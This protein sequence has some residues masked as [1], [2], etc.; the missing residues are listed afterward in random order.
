MPKTSAN[1]NISVKALD[2]IGRVKTEGTVTVFL[3][4]RN[5]SNFLR[6]A[7]LHHSAFDGLKAMFLQLPIHCQWESWISCS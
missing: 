1:L 6:L 2:D 7:G 3:E 5:V 4:R